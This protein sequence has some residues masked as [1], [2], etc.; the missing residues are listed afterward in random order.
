[1]CSGRGSSMA[2]RGVY[3]P[4]EMCEHCWCR[5]HS[6]CSATGW[7]QGLRPMPGHSQASMPPLQHIR[8]SPIGKQSSR[9]ER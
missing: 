7:V 8:L 6:A 1:M 2:T 4:D 3:V 9:S 5:V